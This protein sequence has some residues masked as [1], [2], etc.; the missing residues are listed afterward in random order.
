MTN[1]YLGQALISVADLASASD[2][3]LGQSI[4]NAGILG[5]AAH[6]YMGQAIITVGVKTISNDLSE[7]GQAVIVVG[8]Y[9]IP[10]TVQIYPF[11]IGIQVSIPLYK[12]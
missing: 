8:A 1:A 3:Y 9:S 4:I 12:G 10:Y 11:K 5:E 2:A 7:L 6:A